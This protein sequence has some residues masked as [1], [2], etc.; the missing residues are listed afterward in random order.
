MQDVDVLI[1]GSEYDQETI[2]RMMTV[3]NECFYLKNPS[4]PGAN[5]KKLYYRTKDSTGHPAAIKIDVLIPG[6]AEIPPFNPFWIND[7]YILPVAPL[8]LVLLHK[9]LGWR[10]RF[11]S[12]D[13][14]QY[15]KHWRDASDVE[16]L[17]SHTSK[18][19]VTIDYGVLP[20]NFIDSART[21]VREFM[22]EYPRAE[23]RWY[24]E[25]IGFHTSAQ[26]P[27]FRDALLQF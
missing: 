9:V 16:Y 23:I 15:K 8:L 20:E 6:S 22:A 1:L 14:Y 12:P 25:N 13:Y 7:R 21:W 27:V 24:W 17:V 26:G 11:N 2:K 4:T 19:R 3:Q 10:E 18:M 5:W